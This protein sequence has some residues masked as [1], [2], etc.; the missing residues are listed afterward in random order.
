MEELFNVVGENTLT[1]NT[2]HCEG[3]LSRE[4]A[5]ETRKGYARLEWDY[6]IEYRIEPVK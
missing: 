2:W 4:D 3:P 6:K 1:G 5:V